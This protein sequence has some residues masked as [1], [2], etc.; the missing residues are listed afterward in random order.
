M[1][2]G[3]NLAVRNKAID[4]VVDVY[5]LSTAFPDEERYGITSQLRRAMVSIPLNIAEG[6]GRLHQR[7]FLHHLSIARGSLAEVETLFEIVQRL[8]YA[9]AAALVP[10]KEALSEIARMLTGLIRSV[11]GDNAPLHGR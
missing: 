3:Y 6:R 2:G 4:L 11:A 7:E 5:R 1:P 9:P 8:E 10:L